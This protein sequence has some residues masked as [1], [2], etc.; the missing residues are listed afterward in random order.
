MN[1]DNISNTKIKFLIMYSRSCEE[2][3]RHERILSFTAILFT[4]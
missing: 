4:Y 1:N 2:I 3:R